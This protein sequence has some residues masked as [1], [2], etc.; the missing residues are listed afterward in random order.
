[1]NL[2][3]YSLFLLLLLAGLVGCYKDKG[4][5]AYHGIND[6]TITAPADTFHV[7]KFDSLHV[8]P[9]IQQAQGKDESRLK[10]E[11]SVYL[12]A[13]DV[14]EPSSSAIEVL[15]AQRNLNI[16]VGLNAESSSYYSLNFKV[17]DTVSGV[18]YFKHFILYVSTALQTGWMLLEQK[19][20][21]DDIS[22]IT[23]GATI[24]HNIFSTANPDKQ[25]PLNSR[26]MSSVNIMAGGVG[27]LNF[28]LYDNDGWYLD[29]TSLQATKK[30]SQFF[31]G[32]PATLAPSAILYT[33]YTSSLYTINGGQVYSLN[34]IY[35][36]QLFGAQFQPADNKGESIAPFLASGWNYG[37]IFFDQAN[38][39][40]LNDG[41]S[42]A[43]SAFPGDTT[44]AFDMNNVHKTLLSMKA[45]LGNST[46]PDNYYAVFKDIGDDSCFL[47]TLSPSSD[48]VAQ[49]RQPILNSPGV[50][51]SVDYLFSPTL[52]LMYYGSGNQ[53][54]VYDMVAGKSRVI[55]QF[56][57]GEN[58]TAIQMSGNS[59]IVATYTGV[60]GGGS[61]YY[62]PLSATGD[63]QGGTYSNVFPGFEKIVNMVYK[64]G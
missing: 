47:Y 50:G 31:Y 1:M 62:L 40:F 46:F 11:W 17:T 12:N 61:V 34:A 36:A 5:Y 24:Y 60:A 16:Q 25:L 42:T 53:L 43:L 6:I 45:G 2:K 15:S 49:A 30:Y 38:Y 51:S 7:N 33:D 22:F 3:L 10:F 59:V 54:Y 20:D 9:V 26:S 28:V 32:P 4:N 19:T 52:Q 29:K 64:V 18:S 14:T 35:G 39:R 13:V 58:I 41:G 48:P 27:V 21:H 57:G 37:S 44:M 63:V 55:Y 56:A 8:V 23:P